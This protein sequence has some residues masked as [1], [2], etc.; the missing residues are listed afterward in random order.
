MSEI[1]TMALVWV[2]GV[3]LGIVFFGGLWL[4]VRRGIVSQRPALLF[5]GS[6]LLR[7]GGVLIGFYV[8]SGAHWERLLL[9]LVGF[10]VARLIVTRRTRPSEQGRIESAQ[11]AGHAS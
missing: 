10:A 9:C 1:L 5:F 6:M 11:E 8:V 7:T 4:T 3:L 2:A